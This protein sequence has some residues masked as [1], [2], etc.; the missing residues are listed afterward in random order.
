L[1]AGKI[2]QPGTERHPGGRHDEYEAIPENA[3]SCC[4]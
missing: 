4:H 3:G 1:S 2:R